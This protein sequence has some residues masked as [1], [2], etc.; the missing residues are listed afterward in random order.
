[1]VL[2]PADVYRRKTL[3]CFLSTA[4]G[5]HFSKVL[6]LVANIRS[7][8]ANVCNC[9]WIGIQI[10]VWMCYHSIDIPDSS[11]PRWCISSS[12]ISRSVKL[13]KKTTTSWL[14]ILL[15]LRGKWSILDQIYYLMGEKNRMDL[16][17]W[18]RQSILLDQRWMFLIDDSR[19]KTVIW[20]V[21]I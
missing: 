21:C 15:S 1:M 18:W 17:A 12:Y 20:R 6:W 2:L 3:L 13:L 4:L 5:L 11:S 10:W 16:S 19:V 14:I 8:C 9:Q 7:V